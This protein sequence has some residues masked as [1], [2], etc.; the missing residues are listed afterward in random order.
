[1]RT[2][3]QIL[4]EYFHKDLWKSLFN[5]SDMQWFESANE[6]NKRFLK[7]QSVTDAYVDIIEKRIENKIM[8]VFAGKIQENGKIIGKFEFTISMDN[9]T[10][11][12]VR[13][14]VEME[15]F[16]RTD[17]NGTPGIMT[18]FLY[19]WIDAIKEIGIKKINV[20]GGSSYWNKP[21]EK[22]PEIE[23]G[24]KGSWHLSPIK[25][26][27]EDIP[28]C[29]NG[30]KQW[31]GIGR[32]SESVLT[33]KSFREFI[34]ENNHIIKRIENNP[35]YVYADNGE[36]VGK[37]LITM[38]I[39]L[40]NHRGWKQNSTGEY[41]HNNMSGHKFVTHNSGWTHIKDGNVVKNGTVQNLFKYLT[42]VHQDTT[43]KSYSYNGI[44]GIDAEIKKK[45]IDGINAISD[46]EVG[47]SC[48]GHSRDIEN[49]PGF[50]GHPWFNLNT[51]NKQQRDKIASALKDV[52]YTHINQ[53]SF[54]VDGRKNY[55]I[56]IVCDHQNRNGYKN[57]PELG[58]WWENILKAL[59]QF[60]I[61]K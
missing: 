10:S 22:Y 60:G 25:R 15:H 42:S 17:V 31:Q 52:P 33:S 4:N 7:H 39:Y 23:W 49:R 24:G 11:I 37:D 55:H 50:D 28:N 48:S 47:W 2:F 1:M 5:D 8:S 19:D 58:Q 40:D 3:K 51:Y 34:S 18:R 32:G 20:W 57:Q 43:D 12:G 53:R 13:K 54:I 9:S 21:A 44:N 30:P 61:L 46:C 27:N 6:L 56:D 29:P 35:Y 38:H 59:R 41:E 26:V 14:Y 36:E 16:Y 45:W